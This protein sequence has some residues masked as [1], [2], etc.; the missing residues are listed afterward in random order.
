MAGKSARLGDGFG[1]TGVLLLVRQRLGGDLSDHALDLRGDAY[2]RHRL[3]GYLVLH[4]NIHLR[5][6]QFENIIKMLQE[7]D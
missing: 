1:E 2:S 6:A 7:K 4:G 5:T 3:N